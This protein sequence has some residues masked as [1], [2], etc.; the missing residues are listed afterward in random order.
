MIEL[1]LASGAAVDAQ[2]L[3]GCTPLHLA[4][5]AA[6]VRFPGPDWCRHAAVAVSKRS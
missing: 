2:D 1:L 5:S 4:T 6:V 3:R